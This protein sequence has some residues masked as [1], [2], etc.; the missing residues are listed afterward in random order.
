M[1]VGPKTL[2]RLFN[3]LGSPLM[4]VHL[5][6]IQRVPF[7]GRTEVNGEPSTTMLETGIVVDL[8]APYAR[9]VRRPL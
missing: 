2:G 5:W 9:E 3:V 6:T 1:P 7:T 8:L 4:E